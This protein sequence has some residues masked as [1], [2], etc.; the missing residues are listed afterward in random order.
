MG[1]KFL[2][3]TFLDSYVD[4][5]LPLL[6]DSAAVCMLAARPTLFVFVLRCIV[7][8]LGPRTLLYVIHLFLFDSLIETHMS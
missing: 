1:M 4:V 6:C 7:Y 3:G 2:H 8:H 5:E